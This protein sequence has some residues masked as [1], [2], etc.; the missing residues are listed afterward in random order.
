MGSTVRLWV[1]PGAAVAAL[2]GLVVVSHVAEG[3][4]QVPQR[5]EK[6]AWAPDIP[7]QYADIGGPKVRYIK[8]GGGP[9]L[10][11]LHTLR[12][13]LDIYQTMIP[14]LARHFTV[15]ALDYPGHGW[16]DIPDAGYA[17]EDFYRWTAA[18]L[19][20]LAI[21]QATVVGISIGGPIALVLA[22]RQHPAVARI[23]AVNPY[24]YGPAAGGVRNSSLAAR[25]VLTY[26]DTPILGST[27]MR[28]R[29]RPV[30][31]RIVQGGVA[32]PEALPGALAREL[33]EVG[34]RPGHYQ[35]FLSLLANEKLWPEAR[36]EYPRIQV[37]V[38]L[39]Y[40]DQDW[41]P[42]EDRERTRSLIPG[43]VVETVANGGHFLSLDRPVELNRLIVGFAGR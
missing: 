26:A 8:T 42:A 10:I 7:V 5:P 41:A 1:F 11:L 4:R 12:T 19:D 32:A 6:L 29:T 3:L 17:P 40:G 43:V 38:L 24:D 2:A 35:G 28:L 13:Q 33:Y 25:L 31:D 14:E 18:F 37:P 15:Y 39:V 21:R 16:S 30:L 27:I 9:S 22:A 34:N 20:R 23:I 36:K